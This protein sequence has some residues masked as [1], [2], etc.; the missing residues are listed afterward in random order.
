[1]RRYYSYTEGNGPFH[2]WGENLP[3]YERRIFEGRVEY[4]E[5][6]A[7]Q[8][9]SSVYTDRLYQWDAQKHDDLCRKHFGNE[10]Q[11]WHERTPEQTS[12]FLSDYLDKPVQAVACWQV[13]H[14]AN[15]HPIWLLFYRP[16][17]PEST[18]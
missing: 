13:N 6:V 4:P 1:M 9:A 16:V 7:P 12:A 10:S 15:G 14:A 8:G 11:H 5:P 2:V 3:K 17:N 18:A